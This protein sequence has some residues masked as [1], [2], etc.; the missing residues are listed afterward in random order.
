M[1]RIERLTSYLDRELDP[2]ERRALEAELAGDAALRAELR[3][4]ER[5]DEVLRSVPPTELPDGARER[6]D[7]ALAPMLRSTVTGTGPETRR[8]V[9]QAPTTSEAM[10]GIDELARRRERRR[11]LL[12]ALAGVAA[13]ATVIAVGLTT[14][15]P[16]GQM[17]GDDAATEESADSMTAMDSD[18][19]GEESAEVETAGAPEPVVIDD[20]RRLSEEDLDELLAADALREITTL[21]LDEEQGAALARDFQQQLL[22]GTPP[23]SPD[24]EAD[25]GADESAEDDSDEGADAG[26][27]ADAG[28]A[29]LAPPLLLTRDGRPLAA[30]DAEAVTRCLGELLDSGQQAIPVTVELLEVDGVPAVS[31]GLVTL[32]P[33]TS[34]FSRSE[35]W[36]LARSDCQPLRFAQS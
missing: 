18:T 10:G 27:D 34:Q 24:A 13:A 36:T 19:A 7:E 25:D 15:G 21:G 8:A 2:D 9:A 35:V 3:E 16:L 11:G 14:I 17:D 23:R 31:F 22:A 33:E 5:S 20:G 1:D 32:D 12:P 28:T 29:E 26:T 30:E 4:L 6:L